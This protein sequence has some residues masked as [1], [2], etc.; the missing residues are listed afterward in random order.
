MAERFKMV[1]I[2]YNFLFSNKKLF[3]EKYE[4]INIIGVK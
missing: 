2:K 4:K 1:G 3:K